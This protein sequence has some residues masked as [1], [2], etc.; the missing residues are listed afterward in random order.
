[1][2]LFLLGCL[3]GGLAG[4]IGMAALAAAGSQEMRE[5][6]LAWWNWYTDC[7]YEGKLLP[8]KFPGKGAEG[9]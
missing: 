5:E 4:F 8:F 6:N 9:E 1:M 3:V 7:C 2:W